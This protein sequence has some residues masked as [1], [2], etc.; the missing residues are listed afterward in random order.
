MNCIAGNGEI[1]NDGWVLN[2][3]LFFKIDKDSSGSYNAAIIGTGL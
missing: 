1:G 3:S 2:K